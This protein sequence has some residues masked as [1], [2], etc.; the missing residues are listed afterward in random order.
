M[1]KKMHVDVKRCDETA[2]LWA[3]SPEIHGLVLETDTVGEM[4][5]AVQ[6]IA[7]ELIELSS[8]VPPDEKYEIDIRYDPT[9]FGSSQP[10]RRN[11]QVHLSFL[12]AAA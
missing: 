10:S 9:V 2:V 5:D 3:T 6:E 11:P 8:I 7:P 1:A 4:I 12:P